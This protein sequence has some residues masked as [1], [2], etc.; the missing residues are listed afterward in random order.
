MQ[1]FFVS[2]IKNCMSSTTCPNL[3]NLPSSIDNKCGEGKPKSPFTV[4][5]NGVD[6]AS[7]VNLKGVNVTEYFHISFEHGIV[8]VDFKKAPSLDEWRRIAGKV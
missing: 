3:S 4:Y 5:H 8:R 1:G 6:R 7:V 2:F